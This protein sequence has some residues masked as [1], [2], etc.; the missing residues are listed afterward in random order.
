MDCFAFLFERPN[1]VEDSGAF[2]SGIS[3]QLGSVSEQHFQ[4]ATTGVCSAAV[5]QLSAL[6]AL[7]TTTITNS[8]LSTMPFATT[9]R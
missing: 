1:L 2:L 7:H 8:P 9:T 6:E 3:D 5:Y 4:I